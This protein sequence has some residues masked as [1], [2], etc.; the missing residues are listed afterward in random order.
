MLN[1]WVFSFAVVECLAQFILLLLGFLL[2]LE[3][4]VLHD[5]LKETGLMLV[6]LVD[7][8]FD[9]AHWVTISLRAWWLLVVLEFLWFLLGSNEFGFKLNLNFSELLIKFVVFVHV[10]RMVGDV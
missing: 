6:I 8:L 10:L 9:W 1:D 4:A 2:F 3:R 7:G 5:I